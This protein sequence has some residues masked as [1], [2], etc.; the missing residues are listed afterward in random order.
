MHQTLPYLRDPQSTVRLA[1]VRFISESQPLAPFGPAGPFLATALAARGNPVA[2]PTTPRR[3][4]ASL[5][6]LPQAGLGDRLAQSHSLWL[7]V[8][9]GSA[10]RSGRAAGPGVT[11]LGA[12]RE[13]GMTELSAQG[14]PRRT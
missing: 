10:L 8:A 14:A 5:C 3:A 7:L 13:Q 9:P 11:L 4:S 1:A 2:T 6:P 12:Q